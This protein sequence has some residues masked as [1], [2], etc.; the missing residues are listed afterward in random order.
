M[1]PITSLLSHGTAIITGCAT[2]IGKSIAFRLARDGY[3]VVLNDLPAKVEALNVSAKEIEGLG[4]DH[5]MT[6]K[7]LVIAADISSEPE[8]KG[9]I[10]ATVQRFGG[11]DVVCCRFIYTS[12]PRSFH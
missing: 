3:N 9:L 2:G 4:S 11:L 5:P 1:S 10:D 8:V 12:V 7:T 6:G